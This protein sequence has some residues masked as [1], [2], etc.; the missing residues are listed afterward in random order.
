V[1]TD[2]VIVGIAEVDPEPLASPAVEAIDP[3]AAD[4][5][6]RSVQEQRAKLPIQGK[7]LP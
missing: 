4:E 7:N 5:A 3:D 2:A 1:V 6:H